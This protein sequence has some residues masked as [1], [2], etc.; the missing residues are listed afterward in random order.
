VSSGWWSCLGS[1]KEPS[2]YQS[3]ALP[4]GHMT[5]APPDRVKRPSSVLETEMLSLHQGGIGDL[6]GSRTLNPHLDRVVLYIKLQDRIAHVH[7]SPV[8][9]SGRC[10]TLRA[11][12]GLCH[13]VFNR[14][15]TNRQY[16]VIGRSLTDILRATTVCLNIRL[17]P[18]F[19]GR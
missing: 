10:R 12:H 3:D 19:G 6:E 14:G 7:R 11:A 5:L 16:G 8:M 9:G 1:N 18:H 4:L 2:D 15:L 17:R 13:H